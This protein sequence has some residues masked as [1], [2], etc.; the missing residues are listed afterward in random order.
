MKRSVSTSSYVVPRAG[1]QPIFPTQGQAA[2]P[3]VAMDEMQSLFAS[4]P[5]RLPPSRSSSGYSQNPS[6]FQEQPGSESFQ[7]AEL[8]L[9]ALSQAARAVE[10]LSMEDED[11]ELRKLDEDFQKN[12]QRAKKVFDNRMDNLQRSQIEREAQHKKTLEKHQKERAEFEKRLQ[13]EAKEQNRRIEQLQREW[14]RKREV[15]AK[16]K[17]KVS[18]SEDERSVSP[19]VSLSSSPDTGYFIPNSTVNDEAEQTLNQTMSNDSDR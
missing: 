1:Q 16:N 7:D 5:T 2:A 11:E 14:D 18:V 15:L 12:L 6:I 8:N 17:R 9:F 4:E 3:V 19:G 13:Q 10:Q